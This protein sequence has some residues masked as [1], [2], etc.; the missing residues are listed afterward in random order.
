MQQNYRVI[1]PCFLLNDEAKSSFVLQL[2]QGQLTQL[3]S[4]L[5]SSEDD[6]N[7]RQLP[8]CI[9]SEDGLILTDLGRR[10]VSILSYKRET[11]IRVVD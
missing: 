6:G 9:Q 5:G 1:E 2:N 10:Q 7:N 3:L 11:C 8:D 4:N